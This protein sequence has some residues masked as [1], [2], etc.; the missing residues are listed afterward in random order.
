M[1]SRKAAK[2]TK[3]GIGRSSAELFKKAHRGAALRRRAVILQRLA[4]AGGVHRNRR[5]QLAQ[6]PS[7]ASVEMAISAPRQPGDLFEGALGLGS[8]PSWNRNIGTPS[9]PSSPARWLNSSMSSSMQS[10]T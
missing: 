8:R 7:R 4:A 6:L 2:A 9:R 10:P 1:R 5:Q 3:T